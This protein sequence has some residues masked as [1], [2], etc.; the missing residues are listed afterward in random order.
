MDEK[1]LLRLHAVV[2]GRVQGVGFRAFVLARA[3]QLS[4]TGWVRNTSSGDVEVLAEG[5]RQALEKFIADLMQGPR[6]AFVVNVEHDW[7]PATGEF[8]HFDVTRNY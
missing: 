1:Q 4:L 5:E 6:A 7:L 2:Q 3:S 8:T